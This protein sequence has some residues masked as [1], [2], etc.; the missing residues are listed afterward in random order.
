MFKD[1]IKQLIFEKLQKFAFHKFDNRNFALRS[2][3][4]S[5]TLGIS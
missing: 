1:A 5:S 4:S 3:F 2:T